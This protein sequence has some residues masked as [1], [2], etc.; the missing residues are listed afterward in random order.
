MT[1]VKVILR[2]DVS[3][4]GKR[5]DIVEVSKGYARNFLAPRELAFPATD[6]ATSQ[7]EAM[8]R[9]RD[10]KDAKDREGAEEIAKVLVARTIEIPA[11]VGSGGRLF[12]SVTT[13]EVADAVL[14]QTGI[15]LD[16]KDLQME[17]HIKELGTHHVFARLHA[18]VQFPITVEVV[19]G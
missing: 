3:G 17:E 15:E 18:D 16:R 11:R 19:E 9:S 10:V 12:G 6:G 14:E 5:G 13:T 8:R 4:L 7:A 1:D 2:A